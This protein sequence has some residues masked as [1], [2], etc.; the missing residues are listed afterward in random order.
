MARRAKS[1]QTE[2]K[3]KFLSLFKKRGC[4]FLL[5]VEVPYES[6]HSLTVD[7]SVKN[8]KKSGK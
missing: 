6:C 1:E 8:S 3:T 2:P 5:E 4:F 7:R